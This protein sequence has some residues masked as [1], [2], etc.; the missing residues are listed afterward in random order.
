MRGQI[1]TI[2]F[3]PS[4][5]ERNSLVAG[6]REKASYNLLKMRFRD[7]DKATRGNIKNRLTR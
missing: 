3:A 2:A 4:L 6:S 1:D 7:D 5:L